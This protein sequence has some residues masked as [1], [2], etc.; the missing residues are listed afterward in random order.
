MVVSI[1]VQRLDVFQN[2]LS[3]LNAVSVALQASTW[4]SKS[5]ALHL[6]LKHICTVGHISEKDFGCLWLDKVSQTDLLAVSLL[7]R[8]K[9]IYCDI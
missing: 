4:S 6:S 5:P 7:W 3:V 1:E 8:D 2:L 9:D